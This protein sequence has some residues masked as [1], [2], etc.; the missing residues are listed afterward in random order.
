MKHDRIL[1]E[2]FGLLSLS[3]KAKYTWSNGQ[4]LTSRY[5][6][7]HRYLLYF[8]DYYYVE[9]SFNNNDNTIESIE[10]FNDTIYLEAYLN[11][12]CIENL[13]Q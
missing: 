7:H 8:L 10:P 5:G 1:I 9:V 6:I 3:L 4:L 13:L 2:D 12:I 11:D